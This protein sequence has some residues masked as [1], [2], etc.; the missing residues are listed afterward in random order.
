MT[1]PEAL[2]RIV[3][4][5]ESIA[6]SLEPE[7]KNKGCGDGHRWARGVFGGVGPNHCCDCGQE[8]SR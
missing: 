1:E 3:K 5:L 2:E 7:I 6:E 8:A 4:A